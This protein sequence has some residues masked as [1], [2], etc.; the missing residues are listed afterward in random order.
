M[1]RIPS[2]MATQHPDNADRYITIQEEPEEAILAC[3]NQSVGGLGIHEVMIDFEGK[4]T[5]YHQTSQVALGLIQKGLKLGEDVFITPRIPNAKKEPVFRQLMSMMSLVETNI[6]SYESNKGQSI[7]ETIVPMIESGEEMLQIQERINSVIE[8]GNKNYDIQFEPYSIRLIPLIESV[9]ALVD[10]DI[11][12]STYLSDLKENQVTPD[13]LRVMFARSDS[14]MSYGLMSSVLAVI[15]AI[16]KLTKVANEFNIEISPILGCGALPFRGHLDLKNVD[17]I[18]HTYAGIRTF[19]IQSGM[20]Y[21]HGPNETKKLVQKLNDEAQYTQARVYSKEEISLLKEMIAI[22]TKHY[23]HTFTELI[24][25]LEKITQLIPKNRDRLSS[26]RTGLEYVREIAHMDEIASM[27]QDENLKSELRSIN[28]NI[29]CAVPRAISF[30]AALYT[31]GLPPEF[32]GVGRGIEEIIAKFGNEG[33]NFLLSVYPQIKHDLNFAL[34]FMNQK[35]AKGVLDESIREMY[36]KDVELAIHHLNLKVMNE[37][38]REEAFY[39]TLLKSIRPILLHNLGKQKD[40]FD[41]Q[42]EE[43]KI[44]KDWIVKLGKLR[45]S[46]G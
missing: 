10:V 7:Y 39:H 27:T 40:M 18:L 2:T 36:R 26:S 29:H 31:I 32:I 35:V 12:L 3:L 23:M 37:E 14:A 20:R 34:K 42:E 22:F 44:L 5:P 33:L 4:M 28:T 16:S 46:L 43:M 13:H 17:R 45:G 6:L 1:K 24:I 19:T 21:D 41:N 25:P 11:I 15:I 8:L 30:T 38:D 9:P